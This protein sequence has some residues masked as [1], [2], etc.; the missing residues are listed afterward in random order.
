LNGFDNNRVQLEGV[1]IHFVHQR[2]RTGHGIPLILSHGWP[3]NFVELLALLPLLTDPAGHGIDGP[4]FDVVVPS[5]PGY[6]LAERLYDVRH[7]T[8]GWSAADTSPPLRSPC[9][10]LETSARSLPD[11]DLPPASVAVRVAAQR[12]LL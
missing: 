9:S 6:G 11:S 10:S 5:L 2:A 4:A 3:S 7:W 8:R 12:P 1:R